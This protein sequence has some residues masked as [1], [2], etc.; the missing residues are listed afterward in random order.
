MS[1]ELF[2]ESLMNSNVK[3][4]LQVIRNGEGTGD[5]NGYRRL[6]GGEL[7]DSFSDHPRRKITA[8][9]GSK[10]I[11][12]TAAGAYQFLER[13]WDS[14][15]QRWGFRDFSPENQDLGA[16]ALIDGRGA[17]KCVIDGELEK[18]V[19]LCNKEWASLPGSP[20]GQPTVTME[21]AKSIY[22]WAG[23]EY[24]MTAPIIE[25]S[26]HATP[27]ELEHKQMPLPA[28]AVA[29]IPALIEKLPE[30]FSI[31]NK[32]ESTRERNQE[33]AVK[34]FEII[35]KALGTQGVEPTLQAMENPTDL[36]TARLAVKENWYE[37]SGIVE[38]GGGGIG[39]A[40]DY[41]VKLAESPV[42]WHKNPAFL[43]TLA[44]LPLIYFVVIWT[45]VGVKDS[46]A[47]MF[48]ITAI[49][50]TLGVITAF[51]LGSSYGSQKKDDARDVKDAKR[52]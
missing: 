22:E 7:F 23:G 44:I 32:P 29:A 34:S 33:L 52:G 16:I 46:N 51:F 18:A 42:P 8:L 39:G 30:L 28:I 13:T 26:I 5:S 35:G 24:L 1:I 50:G 9:S 14:L 3:A 10:S 12:S 43:V 25:K 31:F 21:K 6:F 47:Q 2:H 19:A 48:V 27:E 49:I 11:T 4:F 38:A 15:V 40:R 37:L 45:L 36:H 17:L 41:N 20:Y